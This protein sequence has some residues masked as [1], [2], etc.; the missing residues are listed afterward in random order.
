M[1]AAEF[2]PTRTA[3]DHDFSNLGDY[4][5][6]LTPD[7]AARLLQVSKST[8]YSHVSLGRYRR[9]THRGHPLRFHRDL[10]I[11]EFFKHR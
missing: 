10:L 2:D 11:K 4:P 5:P 1:G 6:I 7:Q 3:R 9:A 8:L